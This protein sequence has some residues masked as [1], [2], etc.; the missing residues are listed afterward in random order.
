MNPFIVLFDV[1]WTNISSN[2]IDYSLTGYENIF[3]V[4][5]YPLIFIGLIGY[6]YCVNHSAFSAAAAI[7]I[8][9]AVFGVTGV[10]SQP[11]TFNF[12]LI[13]WVV[14]IFSFAGLFVILI[15]KKNRS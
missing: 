4:W 2:W 5:V 11:E 7:C 10:F 3:G 1:N 15:V 13:S 9:F 8:L 14:M 12:T 6:V